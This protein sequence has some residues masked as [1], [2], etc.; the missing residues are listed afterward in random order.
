MMERQTRHLKFRRNILSLPYNIYKWLVKYYKIY[1]FGLVFMKV[2]LLKKLKIN[3]LYNITMIF[4]GISIRA[5]GRK[6]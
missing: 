4:E 3:I 2:F 5:K 1:Y 6:M